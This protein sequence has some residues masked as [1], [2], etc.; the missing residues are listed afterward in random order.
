ME[1]G[2]TDTVVVR[3]LLPARKERVFKAWTDPSQVKRWWKIGEGWKTLSVDMDLRVGGRFSLENET[4]EGNNLVISGEFLKVQPP[5][6]LV[7]TWRF[8]APVPVDTLVTVEFRER[9]DGT[10]V[11]VRHEHT[12]QE[13]GPS[14]IAGWTM[15]L[16]ELAS[17]LS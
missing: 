13:M 17:L 12:G 7:Y 15:A 6:R 4:A 16:S 8:P 5:D 14:A 2:P 3:K 9:G 10:E 1:S 11:V